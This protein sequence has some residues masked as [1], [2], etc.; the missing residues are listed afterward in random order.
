MNQVGWV[1]SI[2]KAEQG[3]GIDIRGRGRAREVLEINSRISK[4]TG[5]MMNKRVTLSKSIM[6]MSRGYSMR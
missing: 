3:E 1:V 5:R 2:V 6:M 4:Q